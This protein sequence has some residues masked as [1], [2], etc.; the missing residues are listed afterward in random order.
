MG[1][2]LVFIMA[3]VHEMS[4]KNPK[5]KKEYVFTFHTTIWEVGCFITH[6][7]ILARRQ[8]EFPQRTSWFSVLFF[9]FVP[10]YTH[11]LKYTNLPAQMPPRHD[12]AQL[13]ES[14]CK[15]N[16]TSILNFL[17]SGQ[18]GIY[19]TC[20]SPWPATEQNNDKN[21]AP[22]MRRTRRVSWT[23]YCQIC[24][25]SRRIRVRIV[26]FPGHDTSFFTQWF[27]LVDKRQMTPSL[28]PCKEPK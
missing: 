22:D 11:I 3:R 5:S 16:N 20:S 19:K 21:T 7:L 6:F 10:N 23:P 24:P 12:R 18:K 17:P 27:R 9:F 26:G 14:H 25:Y 15:V 2:A 1:F 4:G 8:T 28:R 13:F